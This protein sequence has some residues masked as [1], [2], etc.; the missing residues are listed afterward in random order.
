[1]KILLILAS[2]RCYRYRGSF[3]TS[4]TYAPLTLTTLAALIPE[5]LDAEVGLIDEGVQKPDYEG[6]HYDIVGISCVTSSAVRAYALSNYWKG[7]GAYTVLGG[8]HPSLC[9]DEALSKAD[10]VFVGFAEKSWPEFLKDYAD[11]KPKTLYKQDDKTKLS[12]PF[13]RRELL[14]KGYM[15]IPTVIANR[16]CSNN[17][18]FC[19]LPKL[20]GNCDYKRPI[21]EV[22]DEVKRLQSKYYLFLDPSPISDKSYAKEFYE[23]LIPLNIK[24]GGLSSLDVTQDKCLLDLMRRSGCI[25][26]LL[27]FES[28]VQSNMTSSRKF[29]NKVNQYKEVVKTIH[30]Y[31]MAILGCFVLGFDGDTKEDLLGMVDAI[32]ELDIELPRYAVL[33]PFPGT[34]QFKLLE[35]EDRILTHDWSLYDTEHVVFQPA[36]MSPEDLQEALYKAWTRTYTYRRIFGKIMNNN[37]VSRLLSLLIGLGFRNYGKKLF[38][39]KNDEYDPYEFL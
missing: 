12:A 36:N 33:T 24:W 22:I 28:L 31:G 18:S 13:P 37:K 30:G 29:N 38:R 3:K 20:W 17:C 6:K 21:D 10:T 34:D 15:S 32:D 26:T 39:R 4:V 23:A 2:D 8:S 27:G 5:E 9:P 19:S 16:G 14:G 7:K 11:G 25:G 1:M 35:E